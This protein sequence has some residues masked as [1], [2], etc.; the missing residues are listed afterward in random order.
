MKRNDLPLWHT[1]T[2]DICRP[3]VVVP[4]ADE[5]ERSLSAEG[6]RRATG[7]TMT[8]GTLRARNPREAAV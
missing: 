3:R 7:H 6:H 1:L 8:Y 4:F 5:E 2:C